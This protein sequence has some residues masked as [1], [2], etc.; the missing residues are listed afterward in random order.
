MF[1]RFDSLK[2]SDYLLNHFVFPRKIDTKTSPHYR[3]S[4]SKN[5]D[6]DNPSFIL[7]FSKGLREVNEALPNLISAKKR[8]QLKR[9]F[10]RWLDY[11]KWSS[12]NAKK[13]ADAIASFR[14]PGDY[15]PIIC[16]DKNAL[17]VFR[18]PTSE[19]SDAILVN[20]TQLLLPAN[21]FL[22]QKGCPVRNLPDGPTFEVPREKVRPREKNHN[23]Y[24]N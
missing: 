5:I 24:Q 3:Q 13:L 21:T 6:F 16:E 12:L 9:I 4:F 20:A 8:D 18:I 10:E 1:S 14:N 2:I 17:L 7:L 22:G 23:S 11:Q 19:N 15:L